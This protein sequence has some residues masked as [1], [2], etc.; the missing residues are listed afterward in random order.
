MTG[1]LLDLMTLI[2]WMH[3]LRVKGLLVLLNTE[4]GTVLHPALV[5]AT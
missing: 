3:N 5:N 2:I 4:L 1:K